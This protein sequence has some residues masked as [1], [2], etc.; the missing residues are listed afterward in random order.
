MKGGISME[1]LTQE[2]KAARLQHAV[3]NN[4]VGELCKIYDKLGYVEMSAPALG[5]ACRFRGLDIVKALVEKGAT[6]DFPSTEEIEMTYHC[7][8]GKNHANYRENYR[9][10]YSLYLLKSYRGGL[11]G[12]RCL[13]GM[14]LTQK[15]MREDGEQ[16]SLLADEE[17]IA[18][19]YFLLENKQELSFQ[20]EEMLFYAIFA[21]DFVIYDTLKEHN[22]VLLEKRSY[23]ITEGTIADGYWFEFSSLTAKLADKDYIQVMRQL[24]TELHGK[25]YRFTEKI[26]YSTQK[27]FYNID[28]FSFFL[29]NFRQEKMKKF[30]IIRYLIDENA[31][32]A[33]AVIERQ[34]WL[35]TPK[36]RDEMIL[37]ASQNKKTEALAWLL[38]FKNRT[39]NIAAEQE[40]A[41]RKLMRELGAA[42]GSV[43]ALR[44]IWNYRKQKDNT[45]II[46]GYKGIHIEVIVPEKIGK[47]VVTAIGKGIFAGDN[48]Y[49][50]CATQQQIDRNKKITKIVLPQ[51]ITYIGKGAFH[52]LANLEQINI[53][54]GVKEI[55]VEAFSGCCHLRGLIVSENIEK[56]GNKAF[57]NCRKLEAVSIH[58][59]MREVCEGAFHGCASLKELVIPQNVEKIS[60][61]AFSGCSSL[62]KLTIPASVKIIGEEAF[63]NC[64]KLREVGL[65][66]GVEEIGKCAFYACQN[67]KNI[68]IPKTVQRV[69]KEAFADC[70][71][72]ETIYMNEGIQEIG[73][74]AFYG[75][76]ALRNVTIPGTV[77]RVGLHAFSGCK[78]L[79]RV[80]ICEGVQELNAGL[81]WCCDSLKEVCVPQSVQR[82]KSM[83]YRNIVYEVFG[84]C[85][86]LTVICPKGSD[87]EAYC[88]EKGFRFKDNVFEK[89]GV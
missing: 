44:Q 69:G 39:A 50:P 38:D 67:L 19:L 1:L 56:I 41:D 10:N 20:P 54:E 57:Y 14:K 73:D 84:A 33:L 64:R 66:E 13:Q 80:F 60:K 86:N 47:N 53:P 21:K 78:N 88:R 24:S 72:I 31:I 43:T 12:A 3:L 74:E 76:N 30:S 11:K 52:E 58:K 4:S 32:D 85:P 59:D 16:L 7:H 63:A 49:K 65:C 71:S 8:I 2:E 36:K 35:A 9:T 25:P 5:L 68:I 79:E 37:Y 61:D 29:A 15:I 48:T 75:C 62:R 6:F 26:L 22:I 42:P 23:A 27:R 82:L 28:I 81:F 89:S 51:T 70:R 34:G 40:K 46:T 77:V 83:E 87:T 17:R 45:L 55:D 18:V